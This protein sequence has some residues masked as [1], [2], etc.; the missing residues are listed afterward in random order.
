M[1]LAA[2][3]VRDP[4][5]DIYGLVGEPYVVIDYVYLHGGRI[6]DDW[7]APTRLKVDDP[8]TIEAVEMIHLR[9]RWAPKRPPS[10][11]R[12]SRSA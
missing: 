10:P 4:G 11:A 12:P 9:R 3:A 6:V 5:R 8:E 1:L 2:A 7:H